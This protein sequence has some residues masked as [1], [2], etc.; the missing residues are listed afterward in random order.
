MLILQSLFN[1]VTQTHY[2]ITCYHKP[3]N[4][5]FFSR[6]VLIKYLYY[7]APVYRR[8]YF[9]KVKRGQKLS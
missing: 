3:I 6:E 2:A 8:K 9:W 5:Y 1:F 4:I 7:G